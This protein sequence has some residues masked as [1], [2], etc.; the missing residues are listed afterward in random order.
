MIAG[1][2]CVEETGPCWA[3]FEEAVVRNCEWRRWEMK[4]SETREER[5]K[6]RRER[7]C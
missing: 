6:R 3:F 5:T 2:V 1:P 4:V 7:L